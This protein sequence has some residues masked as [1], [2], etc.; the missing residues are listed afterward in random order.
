LSVIS[1]AVNQALGVVQ[2]LAGVTVD[3]VV[4]ASDVTLEGIQAV[5]GNTKT[6]TSDQ[7]GTIIEAR[8][9]DWLIKA[10]LIAVNRVQT[11]PADGDLVKFVNALSQ[12]ETYEV[13]PLAGQKCFRPSDAFGTYLRIHAKLIGVSAAA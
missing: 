5:K 8:E 12:T 2:T 9:V 11:N 4:T 3:Y 13:M 10:S 1:N 7:N 6:E